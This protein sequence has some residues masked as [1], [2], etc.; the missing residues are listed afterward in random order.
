MTEGILSPEADK[1]PRS[2]GPWP[3][4]RRWKPCSRS[5]PTTPRGI[6]WGVNELSG[7][8]D[9]FDAYHS[10]GGRDRQDALDLY[11]GGTKIKDRVKED[12][13]FF[14]ENWS[15]CITG[16]IQDDKLASMV[17]GKG[18][19]DDGFLQRFLLFTAREK[20]HGEDREPAPGV[21]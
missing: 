2:G 20:G 4:I 19:D 14:V 8:V 11:D 17:K 5:W 7:L 18:L 13:S 9:A 10:H 21:A 6:L 16:G 12:G 1:S 15:A 3:T